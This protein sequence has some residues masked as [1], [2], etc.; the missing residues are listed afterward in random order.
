MPVS[1]RRLS[2][3]ENHTGSVN[4]EHITKIV[5]SLSLGC[6][7]SKQTP[8]NKNTNT[9][10]DLVLLIGWS[11]LFRPPGTVV[12][13]GLK[14][15]RDVSYFFFSPRLLR[16]PSTDRPE[17]LPHGRNVT[18]FYNPTPKIRGRSPPKKWGQKHAQ[19][20]SI[21]DHFRLWSQI[22]PERLKISKI[23]KLMFPDR[24]LLRSMKKIG[25]T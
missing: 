19:F 5:V 11:L 22:S 7:H 2:S 10:Y 25:W 6:A 13:D 20:R 16:A 23:W 21:L 15:T 12:P 1:L 17:T 9:V 24:F 4:I 8:N 18:V 3:R 14:F